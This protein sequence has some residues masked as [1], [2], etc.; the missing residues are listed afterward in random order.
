M[1]KDDEESNHVRASEP[2][3]K[4]SQKLQMVYDILYQQCRDEIHAVSGRSLSASLRFLNFSRDPFP[5]PTEGRLFESPRWGSESSSG[6][7]HRPVV[8]LRAS[9]VLS[10]HVVLQRHFAR[11]RRISGDTR[12]YPI[13]L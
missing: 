13:T 7:R 12:S 6:T 9:S 3:L 10:G 1:N 8:I 5:E 2:F 4:F 11:F